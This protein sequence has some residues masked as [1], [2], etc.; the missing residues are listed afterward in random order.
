MLLQKEQKRQRRRAKARAVAK[1]TKDRPRL[2][3]TRS[4][5]NIYA[6]IIDDAEGK[7]I[8]S[9]NDLRSKKKGKVDRAKEVGAELAKKAQEKKVGKVVFDRAG[10][11]Y[12]GR[13]KALADAAREAGIQF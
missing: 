10:L 2:V 4:L 6:Q 11:R 1:G 3:V 8:A 12:H 13:I 7:T 5:S 9:A